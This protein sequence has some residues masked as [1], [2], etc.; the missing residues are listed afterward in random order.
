VRKRDVRPRLKARLV[1]FVLYA[2]ACSSRAPFA[3]PVQKSS[4]AAQLHTEKGIQAS[5]AGDLSTA[6]HQLR[7]AVKLAPNDP[8]ILSTLGSILGM[9]QKLPEA[10]S[11]FE[12]AV[13][14]DPGNVEAR[15]HLA[16]TQW[17]VGRLLEA[18]ENLEYILST[19]PNDKPTLLLA[20]MVA[21]NLKD[22]SAAAR[23]LSRVPE[24]VDQRP[25]VQLALGR[26]YYKLGQ[27]EEA[28]KLLRKVSNRVAD[29]K[30]VFWAGQEAFLAQD[31]N[32]AEA[33]FLSIQPSY[34]DKA[35]LSYALARIQYQ[36]RRYAQAQKTLSELTANGSASG[37][38]YN[39]LG[40][41]V[42]RQGQFE[43]AVRAL[44]RA[45]KLEPQKEG[46]HLDLGTILAGRRRTLTAALQ[47]AKVAIQQFP[48]SYQAYQLK[49][50]V[51]THLEYYQ[52]A[53]QSYL[54]AHQLNPSAADVNVGLAVAQWG[55]GLTEEAMATFEHGLKLFPKDPEHLKEYARVLQK[56]AEQ[57]DRAAELRAISL[58]KTAISLDD[59]QPEPFYQLGS[60]ALAKG[61]AQEAVELLK[62]AADLDPKGGKVHFA[63][64]RAYRRLGRRED[65]DKEFQLYQSLK[66]EQEVSLSG[67]GKGGKLNEPQGR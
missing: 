12:K 4:S 63:L 9:Q 14:I 25:E 39:L 64:S 18:R 37:E 5:L 66:D 53:V 54:R 57:G 17:Q 61:N 34:R 56:K 26:S 8:F 45:V 47:V 59:S 6:E 20:G 40:W 50:L 32:T 2:V 65:A 3:L 44:E 15:R 49:G 67:D 21:E 16:A 35:S 19:H 23:W 55:A 7:E 48:D 24:L 13:K 58:L 43:E 10:S 42:F 36:T 60:L 22:Y 46:Y 29:G 31:Y 11:S 33:L 28:R 30:F 27:Q 51:E 1:I 52:D 38:I 62:R 41:C